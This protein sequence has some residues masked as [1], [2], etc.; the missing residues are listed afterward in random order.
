MALPVYRDV[1][2]RT[3]FLSTQRLTGVCPVKLHRQ[4]VLYGS[5]VGGMPPLEVEEDPDGRLRIRDGMTW[6]TRVAKLCP[7]MT[8]RVAIV[9]QLKRPIR[10][11][12]TIAEVLP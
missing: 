3:L 7:G 10:N 4:I 1:D 11:R 6:A 8:V 5:S 12:T 9:E 2:P